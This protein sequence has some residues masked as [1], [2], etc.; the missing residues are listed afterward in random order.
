MDPQLA[1]FLKI[2]AGIALF[3]AFYRLF[4]YKDTFFHWRRVALLCFF[5]LSLVYPLMNLQEW[6]KGQEPMVAMADLYT[7]VVLQEFVVEAQTE[8]VEWKNI[9]L[10]YGSTIYWSGVALLLFRFLVQLGCIIRLRIRCKSKHIIGTRVHILNKNIGPFSFFHWI[11][12]HPS[13]HTDEEMGEILTHELT[14]ARQCHSADV[15]LSELMCIACWFNPFAWLMKRE[16]RSNLEYMADNRVIENGYDYQ[17]YQFHLLGLAHQKAAANLV[18][19]FNVLPIKNRIKM[20]NKKRTKEIGRAKYLMFLPLAALLMIISNIEAVARTTE[21]LFTEEMVQAVE[22]EITPQV[23]AQTPPQDIKK[24][25]RKE[26]NDS[27][28]FMVVEQMPNFPGGMEALMAFIG[29]NVKYPTKAVSN[30]VQ[31]RVIVEFVVNK[32]GTIVDHKVIRGVDLELDQ[33][34]IR[35]VAMMPKWQPGMQR[36]EAVRVKFTVPITFRL[37]EAPK[38]IEIKKE[39]ISEVVVV[40][41]GSAKETKKEDVTFE[42]VEE[43]PKFP[44]GIDALFKHLAKN[45]KYPV[46]A[47]EGKIEGRVI[48]QMVIDKSGNVTALKIVK[49]VSPSLDA[50]ALRVLAML[51]KWEPGKQRGEAVSVR[52]TMPVMFRLQ[53]PASTQ[54]PTEVKL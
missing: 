40:G 17:S 10:T 42:V 37:P 34:A 27:T 29:K 54:T 20:M 7:T 13:S 31:G 22:P 47:Q 12:I 41:Y 14:H 2:N 23:V 8:T 45:I 11:F 49:S 39:D 33:E 15:L 5:A 53:A 30:G 6:V 46:D 32:D 43:M 1:Y 36:G 48:A 52:Y 4:L 3:Y 9:L 24:E 18:N 28:V 21:K 26:V 16:V 44:G 38:A 35:V 25:P 50:E 19:S 51:P